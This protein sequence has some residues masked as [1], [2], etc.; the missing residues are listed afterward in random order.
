MFLTITVLC[1]FAVVQSVYGVGLLI[2]GTPYLILNN[3]GFDEALGILL[4]SSFL[5]SIHQVLVHRNVVIEESKSLLP[6]M[7]G[8]PLGLI[9]ALEFGH[10][11]NIMP[12]LGLALLSAAFIRSNRQASKYLAKAFK[13]NKSKFHFLNSLI[14]GASNLGGALLPLYSSSVYGEKIQALKCTSVFYSLYSGI[15]ILVLVILKK[16]E[17]FYGGIMFMPFC[18]FLYWVAGRHAIKVVSQELFDKVAIV[19][20]W[21]TGLVFLV[22]SIIQMY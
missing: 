3:T 12:I 6:I 10:G 15:Q 4:P 19:F 9:F 5:I 13:A 1:F 22:R 7:V 18:L 11:A 20:F 17:V 16:S 21:C 14:H 8:L 2:F